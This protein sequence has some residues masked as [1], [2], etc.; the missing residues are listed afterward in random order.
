MNDTLFDYGAASPVGTGGGVSWSWIVIGVVT[1][2]IIIAIIALIVVI[3]RML[4]KPELHGLSREQIQRHW[5]EIERIAETGGMGAKMAIVEADK[6]LDAAL[7]SMSM[8]GTTLGERLKFACYKYPELRKVW[9]A[10]KLR[11]QIVHET[12]FEISAS[13]AKSAIHEYKKALKT[14]QVL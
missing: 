11:N 1:V 12:T 3:R 13:Q 6:L 9:F 2:F 14:I 7:K 8:A 4:N 5:A 10:H